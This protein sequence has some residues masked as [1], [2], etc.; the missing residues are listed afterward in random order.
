[1]D[2]N[3]EPDNKDIPDNSSDQHISPNEIGELPTP[4]ELAEWAA[5]IDECESAGFFTGGNTFVTAQ[6]EQQT[7]EQFDRKPLEVKLL[8][9]GFTTEEIASMSDA[10]LKE[11][12]EDNM[13][14]EPEFVFGGGLTISKEAENA[15]AGA[16]SNNTPSVPAPKEDNDKAKQPVQDTTSEVKEITEITEIPEGLTLVQSHLR[17]RQKGHL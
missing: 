11:A 17:C 14:V 4:E 1:M 10:E 15:N 7:Q 16:E 2:N 5:N 8:N 6:L 9:M 13:N 12:V 3:T